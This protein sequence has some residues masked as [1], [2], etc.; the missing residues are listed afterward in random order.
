MR[1][2]RAAKSVYADICAQLDQ[3][4]GY[5]NAVTLTQRTLPLAGDLP[6]DNQ[7]RVYLAVDSA[8]C[9]YDI[10]SRLLSELIA[11]GLV[12][13]LTAAQ[14]AAALPVPSI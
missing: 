10:P 1:Y 11:A 13:E 8:Y 7:G 5:P 6:S 12:D 14:Y 9:D 4:Y 3:A 2:F